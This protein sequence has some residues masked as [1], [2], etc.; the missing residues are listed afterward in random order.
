MTADHHTSLKEDAM[1]DQNTA[2]D[3]SNSEQVKPPSEDSASQVPLLRMKALIR[4]H[5]AGSGDP[6]AIA[7]TI[8]QEHPDLV[9]A[10]FVAYRHS[11][12]DGIV[13]REIR[14]YRAD[15]AKDQRVNTLIDESFPGLTGHSRQRMAAF[16]KTGR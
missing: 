13:R 4:Q 6:G 16:L 9:D 8:D 3:P 1:Y 14:A 7:H 11:I 10:Y 12:L 5:A 15:R 2:N